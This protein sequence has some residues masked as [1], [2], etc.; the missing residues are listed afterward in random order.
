MGCC[1]VYDKD[2]LHARDL[3]GQGIPPRRIAAVLYGKGRSPQE[4]AKVLQLSEAAARELL[5]Q[6]IAAG[7]MT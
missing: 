1:P 4:I 7:E 6:P 5:H 3:L 2:A